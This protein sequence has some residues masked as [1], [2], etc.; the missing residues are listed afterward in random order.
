MRDTTK[1]RIHLPDVTGLTNAV[2]SPM[3][4]GGQ[5]YPYKAAERPR[6]TEG[7]SRVFKPY[8]C[9]FLTIDFFFTSFLSARLLQTLSAV[10]GQLCDLEEENGISR[11]R[12]R[13][14]EMELEECKHQVA[15]EGTRLFEREEMSIRGQGMSAIATAV[16]EDGLKP[17]RRQQAECERRSTMLDYM[18]GT[19]KL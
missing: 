12:V 7:K 18:R 6:E 8:T 5:Y 19:R 2:E 14:L 1:S 16:V 10:Q 4:H 17:E 11:R 15:R 13:E 3:K 9:M